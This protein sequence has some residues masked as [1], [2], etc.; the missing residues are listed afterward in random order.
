MAGQVSACIIT[1]RRYSYQPAR[2]DYCC[3]TCTMGIINRLAASE[4]QAARRRARA[5]V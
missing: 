2:K 1:K 3:P 5:K 4:R